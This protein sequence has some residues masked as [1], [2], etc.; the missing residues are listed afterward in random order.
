MQKQNRFS[1]QAPTTEESPRR[2]NALIIGFLASGFIT[3]ILLTYFGIKLNLSQLFIPAATLGLTLILDIYILVR[4]GQGKKDQA[5]LFVLLTFLITI[6]VLEITISGLGLILA[7]AVGLVFFGISVLAMH[8]RFIT[9]GIISA[10]VFGMLIFALDGFIKFDRIEIPQLVAASPYIIGV[11]AVPMIIIFIREFNRFR[12]QVKITLGILL[13]GGFTILILLLYGLNR[14]NFIGVTLADRYEASVRKQTETEIESTI[15]KKAEGIDRLLLDIQDDVSD[16]AKFRIGLETSRLRESDGSYWDAALELTRLPDGQYDNSNSD[17]ASIYI[18]NT[19]PLTDEMRADLNATIYL[20]LLAPNILSL[21]PNEM[22]SIYYISSYGYTVYYPN[23]D[24][25]N[26]IEPNFDP[27]QQIFYT[28]ATPE[29]N[30]DRKPRWTAPY[31]DPAGAGLIITLSIPVY[32]GSFFKGVMGADVR[33]NSIT[34][35]VAATRISKSG[36]PLLVDNGGLLITTTNSGYKYFGLAPEILEMNDSPTQSILNQSSNDVQ[37]LASQIVTTDTGISKLNVNGAETYLAVATLKST[38]YKF[39]YIAPANELEGEILTS[40]AQVDN[41]VRQT[42]QNAFL[43]LLMLFIGAFIASLIVG[44]VIT[45]PLTRLT[46]TVEQIA[47]GNLSSRAS[48]ETSDESGVLARSFNIMADRLSQTLQGLEDRITERTQELE[49]VSSSNAY[50]ASLFESIARISRIINT[51]K[52]MER[53][54]PQITETISDQLGFYH[55]GIF[56]VD[57]QREYAVLVAANSDGGKT[58]LARSHRLRIGGTGIVGYVTQSGSPRVALDVG[59]DSVYFDNPDL[60]ETHSEVALPLKSGAE[61]IGALD[62]QSKLTNAFS[63][64]DVNILSVLADQVSIAIQ[65][66]RSFEQSREA[67]EQAEHA[68]RQLS[69]TQWSEFLKQKQVSSF[70]FDGVNTA[71][72]KQDRQA[73]A[74]NLTIPILL[75]GVQIG[76]IKLSAPDADKKWDENE[77]AITQATA[78]RASLAIETARLLQDAQKRAAKERTIGDISAKIGSLVN[79]DNIVQRTIQELGDTFPDTDVAIQFTSGESGQP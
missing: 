52:N 75:R 55:V 11:I 31:Q 26:N 2:S 10:F 16:A 23:I 7:L 12:L 24:L 18:P 45:R 28:I 53:L 50:R 39:A 32:D 67:L 66:A 49:T 13:T 35:E 33:I 56:M 63:E 8:S 73:Q 62:V 68:A 20:D 43:I 78:E 22:A 25:A 1:N 58:M 19:Y 6:F 40:R 46:E 21:H 48:V 17:L 70:Q 42:L 36:I 76:A 34:D 74:S 5:M 57:A 71:Q 61:I 59:K 3:A 79:I 14:A 27:T 54:L 51:S 47:A 15:T 30:P 64:E 4:S 69:E 41:E 37:A 9:P 60:P 65:N 77:I 72:V 44:Q 29:N 38:N